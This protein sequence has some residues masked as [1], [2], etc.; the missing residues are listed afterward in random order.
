MP[1]SILDSWL[2]RWSARISPR[3][4]TGELPMHLIDTPAGFVRV[5]DSG[6]AK[7]C[8]VFV[9]D[10]PNVIEHYA[11]LIHALSQSL[12]VVCFDM[13]GFGHSLPRNSYGHTLDQGANTVLAVLDRLGI[14]SA[15]LAFSCANGFYALRAACIAPDR[16]SSL[17]LSQTPSL[18]AM[19]AWVARL[20]PWP[21]KV[22]A[23]GQIAAWVFRQKMAHDWYDAALPK[24][25]DRAP[26]REPARRSL[27]SG[28]CFC[29]AGVVQGLL[30]ERPE[31][32]A[33]VTV[34]CT[35]IWGGQDKSHRHTHADA[36]LECVP[37]ARIVRF[38]DAGHFPDLEQSARY[39]GL[40]LGHFASLNG[41]P[42]IGDISSEPVPFGPSSEK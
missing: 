26:F 19:H 21:L 40:L 32:L 11:G 24:A 4:P 34:P 13:P 5:F 3:L 37:H 42:V 39:A 7:P 15:T 9:P 17:F 31:S 6:S 18:D 8:V 33:G 25:R 27:A 29:L 16:V 35:M 2:A 38:D 22:P 14:R 30:K 20:I 1:G 36:L 10:G 28:G 41:M 12:R 23:V